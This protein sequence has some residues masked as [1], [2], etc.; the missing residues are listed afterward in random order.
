MERIKQTRMPAFKQITDSNIDKSTDLYLLYKS[1]KLTP[2]DLESGSESAFVTAFLYNKLFDIKEYLVFLKQQ[3]ITNQS[4]NVIKWY[5]KEISSSNDQEN[6]GRLFVTSYFDDIE[7]T[8]DKTILRVLKGEVYRICNID[9]DDFNSYFFIGYTTIGETIHP[10]FESMFINYVDKNV[11]IVKVI[12]EFGLLDDSNNRMVSHIV[13]KYLDK[14]LQSIISSGVIV[15]MIDDISFD[16]VDKHVIHEICK[17]KIVQSEAIRKLQNN[18]NRK[19]ALEI[20]LSLIDSFEMYELQREFMINMMKDGHTCHTFDL[21]FM[22]L[23][24]EKKMD[25]TLLSEICSTAGLLNTFEY[26][27][28]NKIPGLD[29][30]KDMLNEIKKHENGPKLS[31]LFAEFEYFCTFNNI[32]I[33]DIL[34][35]PE[36]F[37]S[38]GLELINS[39]TA[40]QLKIFNGNPLDIRVRRLTY[41]KIERAIFIKY[42]IKRHQLFSEINFLNEDPSYIDIMS[43]EYIVLYST[44]NL[45]WA[46]RNI[47]KLLK[48]GISPKLYRLLKSSQFKDCLKDV[49]FEDEVEQITRN[50]KQIDQ[51][52]YTETYCFTEREQNDKRTKRIKEVDDTD[53]KTD[54]TI[55]TSSITQALY[56]KI[57][58]DR[59]CFSDLIQEIQSMEEYIDCLKWLFKASRPNKY[60]VNFTIFYKESITNFPVGYEI[61]REMIEEMYKRQ[62]DTEIIEIS[63]FALPIKDIELLISDYKTQIVDIIAGLG[64]RILDNPS[65]P[66]HHSFI[67]LMVNSS[68]L[69]HVVTGAKLYKHLEAPSFGLNHLI[70]YNNDEIQIEAIKQLKTDKNSQLLKILYSR[71]LTDEISGEICRKLVVSELSQDDLHRLYS[72]FYLNP[73]N[74]IKYEIYD[75]GFSLNEHIVIDIIKSL[76]TVYSESLFK[77]IIGILSIFPM[78]QACFDQMITSLDGSY[79]LFKNWVLENIRTDEIALP[80]FIKFCWFVANIDDFEML[81]K[82]LTILKK[83]RVYEII[84]TWAKKKKLEKLTRRVFPLRMNDIVE[85]KKIFDKASE[86]EKDVLRKVYELTI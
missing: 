33:D 45:E 70:C 8:P 65:A 46:S 71:G 27:L 68:S 35:L 77:K 18:Y 41:S 61:V 11:D 76:A 37:F 47:D 53:L 69:S 13:I 9:V 6:D 85:Y 84:D 63:A 56:N 29:V 50:T 42:L 39:E 40:V 59:S 54:Q 60:L 55:V 86:D 3:T 57:K 10:N 21:F 2:N 44:F 49:D 17:C 52:C 16:L 58:N 73:L 38:R 82:A 67:Q 22:M 4:Y 81:M 80:F 62:K 74:Y 30:K 31:R 83:G 36:K 14:C 20:A 1:G 48:I 25:C 51:N 79:I 72:L 24:Y 12:D 78:S 32:T 7:S 19:M 5:L 28:L 66:E 43:N 23:Y 34:D 15:K 75:Y 26:K 64:K